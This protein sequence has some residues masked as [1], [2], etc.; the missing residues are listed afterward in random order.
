MPNPNA[1]VA[2]IFAQVSVLKSQASLGA[3]GWG[4]GITVTLSDF[5]NRSWASA[6]EDL[7]IPA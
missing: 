1:I 3:G 6:R 7:D 5:M 4:D 2:T